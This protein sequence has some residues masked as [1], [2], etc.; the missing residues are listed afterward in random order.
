MMSVN[1]N[2]NTT[3]VG[4]YFTFNV[5]VPVAYFPILKDK[6]NGLL[7]VNISENAIS[8]YPVKQEP[9]TDHERFME[10]LHKLQKEMEG[11]AE[12]VGIY[13]EEDVI[14]ICKEIRREGY[15][16]EELEITRREFIGD[17][18]YEDND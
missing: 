4:D 1:T 3:R 5:N 6:E 16:E 9:D 13:S 11:E 18:H 2:T 12:K 17:R 14:R 7:N 8:I 15:T 10:A